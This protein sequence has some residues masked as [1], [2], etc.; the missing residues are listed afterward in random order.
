MKRRAK[1]YNIK[2][3]Q[4]LFLRNATLKSRVNLTL[5]VLDRNSCSNIVENNKLLTLIFSFRTEDIIPGAARKHIYSLV[6]D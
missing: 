3:L 2:F 1:K 5:E 6:Q 4:G